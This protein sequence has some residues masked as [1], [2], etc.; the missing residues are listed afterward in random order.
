MLFENKAIELSPSE[1]TYD[2]R[3]NKK[4]EE[5]LRVNEGYWCIQPGNAQ[6]TIVGGNLI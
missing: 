6:G 4:P 2:D 3:A 5:T 1:F